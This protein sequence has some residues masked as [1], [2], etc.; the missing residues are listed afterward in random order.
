MAIIVCLLLAGGI[1]YYSTGNE[2]EISTAKKDLVEN[3]K[4]VK[5]TSVEGG[6]KVTWDCIWFGSYP[7]TKIVSSSKEND[8]Y[9]TLEKANGWDK[10]TKS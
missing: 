6:K 3:P 9:S 7:Q 5:D 8:L 10:N 4:I 1:K 2:Q